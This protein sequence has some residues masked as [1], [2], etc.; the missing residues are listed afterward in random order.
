MCGQVS[1]PG[2]WRAR[3]PRERSASPVARDG[4]PPDGRPDLG[5]GADDAHRLPGAGHGRV[6][7]LAAQQPGVLGGQQHAHVVDLAALALVH[8]QRVHRLDL[9][10]P[11]GGEVEDV[12]P[13]LGIRPRSRRPAG[14]R[15]RRS[16]RCRYRGRSRCAVTSTGGRG[17]SAARR[18]WPV[19]CASQRSTCRFQWAT[20]R[21]PVAVGADQPVPVERRQGAGVVAG[22][23]GRADR[24][25]G[26]EQVGLEQRFG[27]VG[28]EERDPLAAGAQ[29][30]HHGVGVAVAQRDREPT[31]LLAVAVGLRQ[32]DDGRVGTVGV[33]LHEVAE[34]GARA[35]GR[36]LVRVADQHQPGVGAQR[37]EQPTHHHQLDHRALVD[38]H[39]VVLEPVVAVV[40]EA[41]GV[42]GPEPE[43]PVQRERLEPGQPLPVVEREP[44]SL[45]VDRL[46][47]PGGRLAGRRREGD[48]QPLSAG[49]PPGRR[50]AASSPATVVVLPV[51]GPPVRTVVQRCRPPR[52]SRPAARRTARRGRPGSSAAARAASSTTGAGR[53]DRSV[54]SS[55]TC[56]SSR[57]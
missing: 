13:E 32:R 45:A 9:G 55:K 43:Q 30:L 44:G 14:G 39:H 20:P 12:P 17:T 36:E 47:E 50:A 53:A 26:V 56:S 52:R 6:E 18:S 8:R 7:Q 29:H 38:H 33:A 49:R 4:A 5:L 23:G 48:R 10:E 24:D 2:S 27:V 25:G 22:L 40:P 11:G 41:G 19:A 3:A 21:G 54:R 34:D 1:L 35:D 37:L 28:L 51:P 15:R 16:R 46:L 57:W 42:V 31:D